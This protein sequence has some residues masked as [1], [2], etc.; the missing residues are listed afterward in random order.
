MRSLQSPFVAIAMS[1]S[2]Q[3]ASS[4]A[5]VGVDVQAEQCVAARAERLSACAG[6][7]RLSKV[8][9][10]PGR[11]RTT[12]RAA[13]PSRW[14]RSDAAPHTVD[15]QPQLAQR[16]H[17]GVVEPDLPVTAVR[18]A[19]ITGAANRRSWSAWKGT[20]RHVAQ[21]PEVLGIS[22]GLLGDPEPVDDVLYH[23]ARASDEAVQELDTRRILVVDGSRCAGAARRTV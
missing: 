20:G 16:R 7:G 18:V 15:L 12:I 23:P 8:I 10:S 3:Y 13:A 14:R 1:A 19:L 5:T 11:R 2:A 4:I 9:T 6:R 22:R 21:Q 17:Q